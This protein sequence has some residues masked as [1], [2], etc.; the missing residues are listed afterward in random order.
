MVVVLFLRI[1]QTQIEVHERQFGSASGQAKVLLK[2]I[3]PAVRCTKL[4]SE[5][6]RVVMGI[7]NDV[8]TVGFPFDGK[9][10]PQAKMSVMAAVVLLEDGLANQAQS[11][12]MKIDG[13]TINDPKKMRDLRKMVSRGAIWENKIE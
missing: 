1:R 10:I 11:I 4:A 8:V 6:G 3:A 13:E 5:A 9:I 12:G 7:F 2:E